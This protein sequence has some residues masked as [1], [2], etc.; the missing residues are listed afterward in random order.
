MAK[1]KV[2]TEKDIIKAYM[3]YTLDK[4]VHPASVYAFAQH[5]GIKESDFYKYFGSFE[6][7]ERAIFTAFFNNALSLLEKNEE[8][9]GFDAKNKLISFYYTFFEVLKANRSYVVFALNKEKLKP[10]H[11]AALSDLKNLFTAFIE[12]IGIETID[13]KQEKLEKAKKNGIKEWSWAQ[14]LFILKF[15]LEDGSA[16][17]EKTDVLIEKSV[18]TGFVLLDAATLSSVFDLGKFLYK[19]KIMGS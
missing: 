19:E 2:T 5:M 10:M 11:P 13:F 15:W 18:S 1:K 12:D 4:G 3:K 6:K 9:Q 8:Y 14:F 7:T 16:D 17:F